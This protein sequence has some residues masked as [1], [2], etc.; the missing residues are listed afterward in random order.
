MKTITVYESNGMRFDKREDAIVYDKL[1]KKIN[2]IM[3]ELLPRTKEVEAGVDFNKHNLDTLKGCFKAFCLVC[4]RVLP[5]WSDFFTQTISGERHISHIG[6]LLSDNSHHYPILYNAYFR[7][8]CINF[9]NGYEFQQPYYV[10][11]QEEFFEDM[12]KLLEYG[13]NGN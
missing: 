10:T 1:C 4:A 8:T 2:S 3:A 5:A 13:S 6:K 12:K 9:E 7:F 11:H